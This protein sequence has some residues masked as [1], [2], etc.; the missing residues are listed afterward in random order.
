MDEFY[1]WLNPRIPVEYVL[2]SFLV[3]SVAIV[4]GMLVMKGSRAKRF[5]L[6]ALLAEYYFLVL[7]S[8]VICRASVMERHVEL[9]PFWNYPD[10]WN[11]VDYPADLIEVLLNMA[12][13]VPIGF[14]LGG[15]GFKTKKVLLMGICLSGII[16]VSQFG[17]CKGLCETDDV[18]H[19]TLG[20]FLGYLGFLGILKGKRRLFSKFSGSL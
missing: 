4:T 1:E 13:F 19:N 12:L 17:F 2:I 10:I 5:V 9:M 6:G 14:L 3:L 18:I 7:C 15:I 8:T 20:A 11:K 16:E